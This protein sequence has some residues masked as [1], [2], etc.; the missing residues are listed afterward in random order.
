M[1][2]SIYTAFSK[3]GG[4]GA[5]PPIHHHPSDYAHLPQSQGGYFSGHG[6]S[7]IPQQRTPGGRTGMQVA[8]S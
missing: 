3:M 4:K 5:L 8:A 2:V 6:G 7:T 1:N